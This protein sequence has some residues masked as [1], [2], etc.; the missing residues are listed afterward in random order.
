MQILQSARPTIGY[1]AFPQAIFMVLPECFSLS[2]ESATDN[3]YMAASAVNAELA[4][5]QSLNLA[6]ALKAAGIAVVLFPGDKSTPDAV[7]PNNAFSS[8]EAQN[9]ESKH[10][11]ANP[12]RGRYFTGVMRHPSR[13]R[14]T[15]RPDIHHFFSHILGYEYADFSAELVDA[16]R[17]AKAAHVDAG[18]A[19][20]AAHVDARRAAKAAHVD[21]R[22]AAKAAL[23]P[24][25]T[26]ELTGSLVIDRA[27]N[28]GFCG[29]SQRCSEAG[30]RAMHAAFGL[31]KTYLFELSAGEYHTNVVLSALGGKGIVL[32]RAG[33]ADS[34]D[35]DVIAA[36]YPHQCVE[37]S[38]EEKNNFAANCIALRA[39]Q[40]WMSAR[41][42]RSL[43]TA[44][45]DRIQSLGL[46]VHSADLSELEK[47]GGSL[48]CMI[49]EIY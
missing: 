17:A 34:N 27:R 44:T 4:L 9:P 18:R 10:A 39:D 42:E 3:V 26:A 1:R 36:L 13:Q 32:A 8:A 23:A 24:A 5:R 37:L 35:A 25:E 20:K 33:F 15:E 48:R 49:G 46:K 22:R 30:A 45:K 7:F 6:G 14:E 38:A 41:A 19:A 2:A 11:D 28:I 40:L 31:N 29:L 12:A 47:A 43:Q 21:A 16:G